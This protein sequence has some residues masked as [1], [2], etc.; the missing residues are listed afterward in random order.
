MV[1][2]KGLGVEVVVGTV[3]SGVCLLHFSILPYSLWVSIAGGQETTDGYTMRNY[4]CL[5]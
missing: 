4:D 5:V 3:D 1:G 2:D